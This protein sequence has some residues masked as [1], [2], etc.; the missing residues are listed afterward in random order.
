MRAYGEETKTAWDGSENVLCEHDFGENGFCKRCPAWFGQLGL[1]STVDLYIRH[2][3]QTFREIK[4]VLKP[5]GSFYLNLG[6]TYVSSMGD[7][8]GETAGF[9]K[10]T[11][12]ADK[13]PRPK[14]PAKG[15]LLIPSRVA[16]AMQD[17]GW[18]CMDEIIWHK[19]LGGDVPVYARSR[20]R[21]LRTTVRELARLPLDE[22][23]LP[24]VDG[25]RRVISIEKQPAGPLLTLHLRNGSKFEAS[26]DHRFPVS[27]HL[28][29]AGNLRIGTVLEHY[30]IS[31]PQDSS[32]GSYANGWIAGL[33]LAEGNYE[34]DRKGV[35]F[36]LNSQ[37]NEYSAKI[38]DFANRTCGLWREHNY[39]NSK[40][41]I[42]EGPVPQAVMMNYVAGRGA[43][44]KHLSRAAFN[45]S[46]LFLRAMLD[47]FLAGDGHLDEAKHCWRVNIT[48]NRELEYDLKTVCNRLG[49]FLRTRA[50]NVTNQTGK[51]YR[52]IEM[53][54][55]MQ[56]SGHPNEKD[57][58]EILKI[59]ASKGISYDIS[60]DG[61]H[62]FLL[63]DGTCV[64]NSNH[65]P[66][67][68]K[69]RL[70]NSWEPI[71]RFVKN[72]KTLLWRVMR[73]HGDYKAGTWLRERPSTPYREWLLAKDWEGHRAGEWVATKPLRSLGVW[74]RSRTNWLGFSQ[75]YELDSIR[76]PH[77]TSTHARGPGGAMVAPRLS[78]KAPVQQETREASLRFGLASKVPA[79]YIPHPGGVPP[80]DVYTGKF[81]ED[82]ES[83]N[84]PRA[85]LAREG[86]NPLSFYAEG[87][88]N[89]G[90]TIQAEPASD[91][92]YVGTGL[93]SNYVGTGRNRNIGLMKDLGMVRSERSTALGMDLAG[94]NPSDIV[95]IGDTKGMNV[96]GQEPQHGLR[97]PG[98]QGD[99][100]HEAGKNPGDTVDYPGR[101][102]PEN[103]P[104]ARYGTRRDLTGSMYPRG[105]QGHEDG[106]N[107]GDIWP[108]TTSA[109]VSRR[110]GWEEILRDRAERGGGAQREAYEFYLGWKQQNPAGTYEQFFEE[111]GSGRLSAYRNM[112]WAE[113]GEKESA[114]P[115]Y[116]SYLHLPNPKGQHPADVM[117]ADVKERIGDAHAGHATSNLYLPHVARHEQGKNP[118]DVTEGKFDEQ[119]QD[120]HDQPGHMQAAWKTGAPRTTHEFGKAAEDTVMEHREKDDERHRLDH[121]SL[122]PEPEVD[123]GRAFHEEGK[124]PADV[125]EVPPWQRGDFA[126]MP[127]P[128][129]TR[130]T[131]EDAAAPHVG[132]HPEGKNPGDTLEYVA[133]RPS[134]GND[135]RSQNE[136]RLAEARGHGGWRGNNLVRADGMKIPDDVQ[137]A[138]PDTRTLGAITG[139]RGA[140]KVPGGQGWLGHPP[141]GGARI[142]RENDPRWLS[143]EGRNPGDFWT[144]NTQ[145][146]PEAHFA[147]Y[148]LSVCWNAI[149]SSAPPDGIVLDPF[150]GSATVAEAVELVNRLGKDVKDRERVAE[151]RRQA[152]QGQRPL[153]TMASR[154]WVMIEISG[155]YCEIAERRL[156]PYR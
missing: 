65:M 28:M 103:P 75:Y 153:K 23:Y 27:G 98:H 155:K 2:L 77:K 147:T 111:V 121:L 106:K 22:L 93:E 118:S 10:E 134:A 101:G 84:S 9:S 5:T 146:F 25:W 55:R 81:A 52:A 59:V 74:R 119:Y 73:D 88:G 39:R 127:T 44:G 113:G 136:D 31:E 7:H 70:A 63:N 30:S 125:E 87:G 97:I 102:F 122:P 143:P 26:I 51:I 1:E 13:P 76:E 14:L 37:E 104:H 71:F 131:Y 45:E 139:E 120:R 96:P 38:K 105:R 11:M 85:R 144:I 86:Y 24:S 64:H 89:P 3:M 58:Y 20:G 4:R 91:S 110:T 130:L 129:E 135:P 149:L 82:P 6:D 107:P 60:V 48:L 148:P 108:S 151:A 95:E 142:V 154:R 50:R 137:E 34:T 156:R 43:K 140:V 67:S 15:R 40:A 115:N 132:E 17:D 99:R 83:V 33:F 109:A 94:K 90:D 35:R 100:G 80:D 18:M 112:K 62:L 12:V 79:M 41:V 36:S 21:V 54:L 19:C 128:G 29:E 42:V 116:A 117:D 150:A 114:Q 138:S 68:V 49:V 46:N 133:T 126:R 124:N 47:G 69:S 152:A 66:S 57:P 123:P 78:G 141:G 92:K 8:G 53:E 16:L 56:R 145:P 32:L 61:D 72:E